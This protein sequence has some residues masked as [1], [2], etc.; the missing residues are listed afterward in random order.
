[1]K[2]GQKCLHQGLT[3]A[4]VYERTHCW[5]GQNQLYHHKPLWQNQ[6]KIIISPWRYRGIVTAEQHSGLFYTARVTRV[7]SPV[8]PLTGLH[9]GLP[10]PSIYDTFFPHH[11]PTQNKSFA[12][13]STTF[14]HT[15]YQVLYG[16]PSLIIFSLL[17]FHTET[18]KFFLLCQMVIACIKWI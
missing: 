18:E 10:E 8:Y 12:S 17:T 11:L 14:P 6:A 4:T 15:L 13:N 16:L 1:M 7:T 9:Q 3:L 2:L 5:D